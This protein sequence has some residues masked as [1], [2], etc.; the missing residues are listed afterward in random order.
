MVACCNAM[1]IKVSSIGGDIY[2]FTGLVHEEKGANCWYTVHA[3]LSPLSIDHTECVCAAS[4]NLHNKCK[5]IAALLL[6]LYLLQSVPQSTPKKELPKWIRD[7]KRKVSHFGKP[8]DTIYEKVKGWIEYEDVLKGFSKVPSYGDNGKK[9]RVITERRKKKERVR[10]VICICKGKKGPK[11][12]RISCQSCK[13]EYHINCLSKLRRG[14]PVDGRFFCLL[15]AHCKVPE[16]EAIENEVPVSEN[17]LVPLV[18][19]LGDPLIAQPI[20]I[21]HDQRAFEPDVHEESQS[22]RKEISL[23]AVNHPS[24]KSRKPRCEAEE[25]ANTRKRKRD[26]ITYPPEIANWS[27]SAKEK[28][29]VEQLYFAVQRGEKK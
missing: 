15:S 2:S 20:S 19:E 26:E 27:E 9:A 1:G 25:L 16:N 18:P 4:L 5:H 3:T 29:R 6:S 22:F 17:L 7:R 10:V 23:P 8:G 11:K 24:Q 28:W 21:S 13:A 12:G 14:V